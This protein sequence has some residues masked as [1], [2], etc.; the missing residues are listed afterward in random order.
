MQVEVQEP[1][2]Y[3]WRYPTECRNGHSWAP[4]LITVSW[5]PCLCAGPGSTGHLR[6]SCRADGCTSAAWYEPR[7]IEG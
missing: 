1:R 7:H 2:P 5:L 4:G 3:R 6:V